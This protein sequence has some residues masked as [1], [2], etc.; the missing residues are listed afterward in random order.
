MAP[1]FDEVRVEMLRSIGRLSPAHSFH[2]VLFSDNEMIEGPAQRLAPATD[3]HKLAAVR[4]LQKQHAS[5]RTTAL[6]ALK[7]AFAA[8]RYANGPGNLIY[9]LSDGDFAGVTGRS[10][11]RAA[12][13]K[14][15]KGNEAV[16][17]WLAEN[18]RNHTVQINTFLLHSRDRAAVNVLQTIA[19]EHDGRFKYIS[20]AE[21]PG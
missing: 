8:F 1:M 19:H 3:E 15:Y 21:S 9:L 2:I 7:S 16:L 11:Y 14:E 6:V 20:P 17:R 18:N 4:F 5:G 10:R 12:D 13:G